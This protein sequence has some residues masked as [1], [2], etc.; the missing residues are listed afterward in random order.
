MCKLLYEL[1]HARNYAAESGIGVVRVKETG[2]PDNVTQSV[3]GSEPSCSF[4]APCTLATGPGSVIGSFSLQLRSLADRVTPVMVLAVV[5]IVQ[6]RFGLHASRFIRDMKDAASYHGDVSK[7]SEK[8]FGVTAYL[9]LFQGNSGPF[10]QAYKFCHYCVYP[11]HQERVLSLDT[12]NGSICD[13]IHSHV[14]LVE[15]ERI[16]TKTEKMSHIRVFLENQKILEITFSRGKLLPLCY[17][18]SW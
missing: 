7:L 1:Q 12:I 6:L 2:L 14:G 15:H 3:K 4:V 10:H 9:V 17:C 5:S 8:G 18:A 11:C 13:I 16:M